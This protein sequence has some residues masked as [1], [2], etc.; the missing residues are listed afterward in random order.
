MR[1]L[2]KPGGY[3]RSQTLKNLAAAFLCTMAFGAILVFVASEVFFFRLSLG[4]YEVALLLV[5]LVPLAA[6]YFYLGRYHVYSGGLEGEKRVAKILAAAL[7]NDYYLING[8]SLANGHGDI[9]HIVLGPNGI[10]VIETKNWSGRITCHGDN[11]QRQNHRGN[12]SFSS[13]SLQVKKNAS[14]VRKAIEASAALRPLRIWV[15]G[16][17]VFANNHADLQLTYPTVPALKLHELANFI[18]SHGNRNNYSHQQ[19][20][21]IAKQLLLK[22][23]Q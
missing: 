2:R 22:Q 16:I 19:L 7:S 14:K 11:W 8:A 18:M 10:V 20:E 3:L 17:V 1:V 12:N 6:F 4:F 5:S 21:L 15:E 9:D 13:P 23:E